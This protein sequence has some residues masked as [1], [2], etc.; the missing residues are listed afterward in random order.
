M[1]NVR[2]LPLDEIQDP[3]IQQLIRAAE[4][5]G[6]P[7]PNVFRVMGHVP[8]LCKRFYAVWDESFNRGTLDHRLKELIRVKM[9]RHVTCTY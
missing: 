4:A 6:A 2:L 5:R 9:S 1:A 7:D 3:D 8:E